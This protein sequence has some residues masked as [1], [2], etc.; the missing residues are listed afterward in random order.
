MSLEL[1][2]LIQGRGGVGGLRQRQGP[3]FHS[4]LS[5]CN[6][7]KTSNYSL[8]IAIFAASLFFEI[9]PRDNLEASEAQNE[10]FFFL[11]STRLWGAWKWSVRPWSLVAGCPSQVV[12]ANTFPSWLLPPVNGGEMWLARLGGRVQ[13]IDCHQEVVDTWIEQGE[14]KK[15]KKEQGDRTGRIPQK[16][17]WIIAISLIYGI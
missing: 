7:V 2:V 12:S 6:W 4:E 8:R 5:K 15:K 10:N 17:R 13:A 1:T 16:A 3:K 11:L 14:E 9:N